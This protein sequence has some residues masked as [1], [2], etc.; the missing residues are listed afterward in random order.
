MI[1]IVYKQLLRLIIIILYCIYGYSNSLIG[2]IYLL[3]FLISK[4]QYNSIKKKPEDANYSKKKS[5]FKSG[6]HLILHQY[7]WNENLR[8]FDFIFD[9]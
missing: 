6:Y 3:I 8:F 7:T 5:V 4:I 2:T 9:F 1:D